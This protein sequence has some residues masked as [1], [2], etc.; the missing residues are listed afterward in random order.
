MSIE[1]NLLKGIGSYNY[2]E[3][4]K[5]QVLQVESASEHPRRADVLVQ[6]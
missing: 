3:A 6:V 5:C 1:R 2:G 4:G